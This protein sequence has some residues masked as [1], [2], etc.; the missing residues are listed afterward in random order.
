MHSESLKNLEFGIII[1][2]ISKSCNSDISKLRLRDSELIN[3]APE[4]RIKLSEISEAKEIYLAEAGF[5]IWSFT[6]I[7]ETLN[8]IETICSYL[9]I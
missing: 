1:D 7:R 4:L 9:E 6:D 2:H 3:N 5:P 8:K